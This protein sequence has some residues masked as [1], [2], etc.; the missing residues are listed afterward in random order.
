MWKQLLSNPLYK[1][2]DLGR[3]IP[4]SPHAIS[5]AM[6]CWQDVVDYEEKNP[7]VLKA[8]E[9]A[10][11][12]FVYHPITQQ[13]FHYSEQLFAG[14]NESCIAF[15]SE[16]IAEKCIKYI[17]RKTNINCR[18]NRFG[19]LD[20]FV[21]TYPNHIAAT[22]KEFW[23]H[24][25]FIISSRQAEYALSNQTI[26]KES[27]SK[28]LIKERIARFANC[29]PN[30]IYLY[31]S[32][33]A[34]IFAAYE[35]A[36]KLLPAAHTI[37][38]GFSYVD[39]IKIQQKFGSEVYFLHN[40]KEI[41]LLFTL[42]EQEKISAVFAEFPTNPLLQS[43][44]LYKISQKLRKHKIP[45]IIDNTIATWLNVNLTEIADI[46]VTSLT[47]FF[48]GVGDVMAG[49]LQISEHS[50]LY[51]QL[52]ELISNDY[53]DLL[54]GKD[55]VVLEANSRDFS[56]RMKKI[57]HNA[58][59][60]CDVLHKKILKIYYP[61][62]IDQ[63]IYNS[64][65]NKDAGYGGLFSIVLKDTEAARSFYDKL[66]I[67]KGPSLGTNYSLACPYTLLAHYH[68]LG[69]AKE[70]GVAPHLIRVS[71]GLEDD[72]IERFEKALT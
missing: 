8:L 49:S 38:F 11:P 43:I 25:G 67:C 37:Q 13:F 23:Q 24:T 60:L 28:Q 2:E 65:K 57:N 17:F 9:S 22:V 33:M 58:E 21:I 56:E 48:S 30:D 61:K 47:K 10:Y 12:R 39:T 36:S 69:F 50:P 1:A 63:D 40:T 16:R 55:A 59:N 51:S 71:V 7:R 54:F 18:F 64:Y 41:D 62:Y 68:E 35:I 53:E 70:C 42:V 14:E 32:G 66:E 45:F 46:I 44:D 4:E 72:L 26:G 19:S 52:K 34:A 29:K 27:G 20:I 3:P 31:P 6:P 15:P 5:A